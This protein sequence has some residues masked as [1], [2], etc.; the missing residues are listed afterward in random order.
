MRTRGVHII[1][2]GLVQGVG[3][4]AFVAR[5]AFALDLAGWVRNLRDGRVELMA[6]GEAEAVEKL[7]MACGEGPDGAQVTDITVVDVVT[8]GDLSRPFAVWPTA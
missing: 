3:Y 7:V 2:T 6:Y 5:G 8:T 4:R 1:V